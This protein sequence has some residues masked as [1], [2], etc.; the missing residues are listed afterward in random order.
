MNIIAILA[1]L[2]LR[3]VRVHALPR[4]LG[5]FGAGCNEYVYLR[6]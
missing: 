3:A 6:P 5:V 4:R 1:A 2:G